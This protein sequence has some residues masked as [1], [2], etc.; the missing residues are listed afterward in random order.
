M[1]SSRTFRHATGFLSFCLLIPATVFAIDPQPTHPGYYRN[2]SV[3]G[4]TIIFTSEGDLW[5]VG[6]HGGPAHRLTSSTGVETMATIS[7]DGQTIAYSAEY[8]G[9]TEVY[10]IPINGGSP[11]RRTWDGDALPA[12]WT[13]DGRL[14]VR[15]TRYSGLPDPKLVLLGSHGEQDMVPL[16]TASE[17][18]YSADGHTLFFTRWD[19]QWSYTK[20]YK[21]GWAQSLWRFDGH[22]EAIPMTA[23]WTGTSHN[24]M[25]WKDRLYFLSDRDGVIN[26]YSMDLDGHS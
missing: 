2:P 19:K 22:G 11:Q 10:T 13:P 23:D 1:I 18:A 9:P 3:R 25:V 24:P 26:V 20:R 14:I 12:G 4:D 6:S 7:P 21:G 15:T 5:S 16:A 17:G 8:E